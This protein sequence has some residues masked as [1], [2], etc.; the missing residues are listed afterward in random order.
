MAGTLVTAPETLQA[1]EKSYRELL[2]MTA[3][4]IPY[5]GLGVATTRRFVAVNREVTSNWDRQMTPCIRARSILRQIRR[6]LY[7]RPD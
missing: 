4:R 6:A 5:Q 7:R 1:K 2:H 3:L